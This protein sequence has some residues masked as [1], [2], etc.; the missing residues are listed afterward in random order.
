[1]SLAGYS[2]AVSNRARGALTVWLEIEGL[3]YAYGNVSK[4]ASWFTPRA[5]GARFEGIRSWF[6]KGQLPQIPPQELDHLEGAVGGGALTVQIV[7]VDGSLTELTAAARTDGRAVFNTAA[8]NPP[9]GV[10]AGA[11]GSQ[12]VTGDTSTWPA[13]GS[14]YVGWETFSYT[15]KA[16]ASVTISARGKYRSRAVAHGGGVVSDGV[17]SNGSD[18]IDVGEIITPY[19]TKL[20]GR[21][22]WLLAGHAPTTID[23][24]TEVWS[25]VIEQ[26][27]FG[28]SDLRTLAVSCSQSF[29][30]LS[31]PAF[32]TLG[33][34]GVK[35]FGTDVTNWITYSRTFNAGKSVF[36]SPETFR[37]G[38]YPTAANLTAE[39]DGSRE[40]R[41]HFLGPDWRIFRLSD[42]FTTAASR[43]VTLVQ[44]M[45]GGSIPEERT[46]TSGGEAGSFIRECVYIEEGEEP[47][48]QGTH[49]LKVL[50]QVLLSDRGDGN[51][52]SWDT[53]PPPFGL[54]LAEDR[55][56]VVGIAEQIAATPDLKVRGVLLR[57]IEKFGEWARE[58]LLKPFGFFLRPSLGNQ[59]SVGRMQSPTP[60]QL[61]GAVTI[62]VAD[63]VSIGNW[64]SDAQSVVG[65]VA[66][67]SGFRVS[68][69]DSGIEAAREQS[70]AVYR[71][72][73]T[74]PIDYPKARTVE[75]DATWAVDPM[76]TL[77]GDYTTRIATRFSQPVAELD[78]TLTLKHILREVGDFVRL[79]LDVVPSRYSATRG[80]SSQLWEVVGKSVSL[81][82]AEATVTLTLRQTA[83]ADINTRYLAPAML[84]DG[85]PAGNFVTIDQ[86]A[87]VAS[88]Q[89]ATDAFAEGDVV[90]A[91]DPADLFNRTTQRTILSI[92]GGLVELDD[93][94]D[95]SDGMV[96]IH[97]DYDGW[98]PLLS[99]AAASLA[100]RSPPTLTLTDANTD[101]VDAHEM[102]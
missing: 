19:P 34:F 50:L 65:T 32:R 3:P 56:D 6:A 91:Y 23:D 17:A 55:V 11:S 37:F 1:M 29:G 45:Y 57:P 8:T 99:S 27:G 93:V 14:A 84:V 86:T 2:T 54:A 21:R 92:G 43:S 4:D 82:G 95:V 47:F 97:D 75:V 9:K 64:R 102:S 69:D 24:C 13:S 44:S 7:D 81:R 68:D 15:A 41:R 26:I 60:D 72:G 40:K 51:N 42:S 80:V 30:E 77:P 100:F 88:G 39:D 79:T 35:D 89:D 49:P 18:R 94:T 48:S 33:S 52:G 98:Q 31:Q 62:T 20:E 53:L 66:W 38:A 63:I 36:Q 25:G 46:Q 71:D 10:T 67:S 90:R 58:N 74:V 59:L 101:A 16:G 70:Y 78:V 22:V 83:V 96:L 76:R 28:N 87:F 61:S 73:R 5:A 85:A 12:T